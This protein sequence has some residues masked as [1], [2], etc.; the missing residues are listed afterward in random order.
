MEEV[1]EEEQ[2]TKFLRK[3]AITKQLNFIISGGFLYFEL[4]NG[5]FSPH[6]SLE[7]FRESA[8]T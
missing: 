8:M 4:K 5:E 1:V 2:V 7:G 6:Q 3:L